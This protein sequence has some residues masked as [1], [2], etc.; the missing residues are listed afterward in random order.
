MR[1]RQIKFF[2]VQLFLLLG[3]F[4]ADDKLVSEDLIRACAF[5]KPSKWDAF[6]VAFGASDADL[7][8]ISKFD[9]LATRLF[10]VLEA[11]RI[12]KWPT[13]GQ[14]LSKCKILGVSRQAIESRFK[15]MYEM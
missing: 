5:V 11:W 4:P 12:A 9:S 1:F 8:E 14:L 15:E 10:M 7:K 3:S 2:Y 13:V 6:G